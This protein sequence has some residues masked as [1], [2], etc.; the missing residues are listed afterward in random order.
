[1]KLS[2]VSEATGRG[3]RGGDTSTGPLRLNTHEVI[4]SCTSELINHKKL[5]RSKIE[6]PQKYLN[7]SLNHHCSVEVLKSKKLN[8]TQN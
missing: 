6:V 2:P 8:K 7:Y 3:G 1:M 4:E 5:L